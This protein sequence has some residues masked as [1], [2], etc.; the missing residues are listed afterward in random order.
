VIIPDTNVVSE[1]LR[2]VGDTHVLRWVRENGDGDPRGVSHAF[3]LTLTMMGTTVWMSGE[4]NRMY[5]TGRRT[6]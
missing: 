4:R 5:P 3:V 2:P 1:L 6:D